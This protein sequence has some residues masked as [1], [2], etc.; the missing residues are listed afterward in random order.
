MLYRL[1][2]NIYNM[3]KNLTLEQL[4]L[5][6]DV[7]KDGRVFRRYDRYEYTPTNNGCGYLSASGEYIHR[8]VAL[9]YIPNPDN[10]PCVNHIDGNKQN[11]SFDNLEWCTYSTNGKHAV[12]TGLQPVPKGCAHYSTNLT[13]TE[14]QQIIDLFVAGKL[15]RD[16]AEEFGISTNA[17][18]RI[19]RGVRYKEEPVDRSKVN[20]KIYPKD[21]LDSLTNEELDTLWDTHS[22]N[23]SSI[24]RELGLKRRTV[25][26][27]FNSKGYIGKSG[28]PKIE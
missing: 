14:L 10:L 6:L 18:S 28:K 2:N 8:L 3:R 16:I 12:S 11:N 27:F 15:Q 21:I 23:L 9:F 7:T 24:A 22:N 5:K 13:T 19:I 20:M 4:K 1:P 17:V 26:G 25:S